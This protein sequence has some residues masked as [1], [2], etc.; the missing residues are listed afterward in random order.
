MI[1]LMILFFLTVVLLIGW[2]FL[3]SFLDYISHNGWRNYTETKMQSML[4]AALLTK[5]EM[6]AKEAVEIARDLAKKNKEITH[7]AVRMDKGYFEWLRE[8]IQRGEDE[9]DSSEKNH[10]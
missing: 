1:E 7:H 2:F 6:T 9:E 4:N 3:I 8:I 5:A 10:N